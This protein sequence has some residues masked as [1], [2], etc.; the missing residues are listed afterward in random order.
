MRA[1]LTALALVLATCCAPARPEPRTPTRFSAARSIDFHADVGFSPLERALLD[2]AAQ[3][4]DFGSSGLLQP[5]I[6]YDLDPDSVASL[7]QHSI[8]SIIVRAPAGADYMGER[9]LGKVGLIDLDDRDT[10]GGPV[11]VFLVADKLRGPFAFQH[12]AM[13]E[14]LHAFGLR[15][16]DD[17]LA[18]MHWS[19]DPR[20]GRL[21]G[22]C[23][24]RSDAQELCR[25]YRCDVED[26]NY[27]R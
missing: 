15:H 10:W 22:T 24:T 19:M 14:M 13:H 11:H 18:L 17:P 9:H 12:A 23:L 27:C 4:I 3:G 21:L 25:A 5:T 7:Q 20:E 16:V 1:Q 26:L 8:D 6:T 2:G